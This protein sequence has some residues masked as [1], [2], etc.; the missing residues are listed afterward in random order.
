M[1]ELR[2]FSRACLEKVVNSATKYG[3]YKKTRQK[4]E[5]TA[6]EENTENAASV[7]S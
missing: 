7:F 3:N 6:T 5:T 4:T 2:R 1:I